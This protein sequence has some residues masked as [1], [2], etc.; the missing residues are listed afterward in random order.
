MTKLIQKKVKFDWGDEKEAPF[1]LIKQKLCITLILALPKGSEDFVVYCDDSHKGLGDILMQREKGLQYVSCIQFEKCHAN[2]PLAIP[3]DGLRFNDKFHFVEEPIK[4]M[5]SEVKQLKRSRILIF[6]VRWNSKRGPEFTW[7]REDHFQKKY[8]HLFTKTP[9]LST[10]ATTTT[11]PPSHQPRSITPPQQHHPTI[12]EPSSQHHHHITTHHHIL[13]VTLSSSPNHHATTTAALTFTQPPPG[14]HHHKGAFGWQP[15]RRPISGHFTNR[16]PSSA[17]PSCRCHH[18]PR[19]TSSSSPPPTT[20]AAAATTAT[21]PPRHPPR[22]TTPP[23]QHHPTISEP[24]SQHH[25]PITTHHHIL[26]VAS[27]SSLN[28]HATTTAALTSTQP[29]PGHHHHK[30]AFGWQ[31]PPR[32]RFV[33]IKHHKGVHLD[34]GLVP[35]A[36]LVVINPTKGAFGSD[37]HHIG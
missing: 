16:L 6:K 5:D 9:P 12:S 32:V 7:E 33:V 25:H 10:A 27:S 19:H 29:P 34:L 14:H 8:P 30:G 11:S 4:I 36:G 1:Q 20:A 18:I 17:S 28:H 24:S 2:E 37:K 31:P 15:P 26:T 3:L 23:Q 13:T 35:R 21:S 22:S